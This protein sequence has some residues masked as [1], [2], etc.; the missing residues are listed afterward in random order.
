SSLPFRRRL[1]LGLTYGG[2]AMPASFSH[3][4]LACG[5]R[6]PTAGARL[7]INHCRDRQG[8]VARLPYSLPSEIAMDSRNQMIMNK[9]H[10]FCRVSARTAQSRWIV[11]ALLVVCLLIRPAAVFAVTYTYTPANTSTDLWSAGTDWSATPLSG[12]GT[13]LTFVGNN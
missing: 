13:R 12:S 3:P 6:E 2:R 1:M 10:L 4:H 8:A 7:T 11:A 5:H 9:D